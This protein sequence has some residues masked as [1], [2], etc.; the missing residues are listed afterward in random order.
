MTASTMSKKTGPRTDS[1]S[2]LEA[3]K[4]ARKRAEEIAAATGTA[5]IQWE[6]G[7]IVRFYPGRTGP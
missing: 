4:R 1:E 5:I 6:D 3:L 7:R 2:A